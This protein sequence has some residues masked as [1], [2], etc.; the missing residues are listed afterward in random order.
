MNW[1]SFIAHLSGIVV[2]VTQ[3]ASGCILCGETS[4]ENLT[5]MVLYDVMS[6]RV[7]VRPVAL[8]KP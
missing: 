3:K 7:E 1:R 5:F 2:L 4:Y 6:L 8:L